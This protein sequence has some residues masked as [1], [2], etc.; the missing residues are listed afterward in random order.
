MSV[1]VPLLVIWGAPH[2]GR[3]YLT[4][5]LLEAARARKLQPAV[6]SLL[7]MVLV[8]ALS[9]RNKDQPQLIPSLEIMMQSS[10]LSAS[11]FKQ[12]ATAHKLLW[13]FELETRTEW[14]SM[15]AEHL[16]LQLHFYVE[17]GFN[18]FIVPDLQYLADITALNQIGEQFSLRYLHVHAEK[19]TERYMAM[20][21]VPKAP[22]LPI[23]TLELM[24]AEHRKHFYWFDNSLD[25]PAHLHQRI[26]ALLTNEL[27]LPERHNFPWAIFFILILST[28]SF[29]YLTF[30]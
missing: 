8:R 23:M 7:D 29:Y 30:Q 22:P 9:A 26:D 10:Y 11:E 20:Q 14:P 1:K 24:K 12:N 28:L 25:G 5:R 18:F 17:R 3:R 19:R 6:L 13:E 27:K 15:L 4:Q 2:A 21:P 16:R